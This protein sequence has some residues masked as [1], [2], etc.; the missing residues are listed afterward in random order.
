MKKIILILTLVSSCITVCAATES[1]YLSS[2][3]VVMTSF[4]VEEVAN[5]VHPVCTL[6]LASNKDKGSYN[7]VEGGI[8]PA[9]KPTGTETCAYSAI[10]ELNHK[11]IIAE[12][13]SSGKDTAI[14][15][16][17]DVTIITKKISINSATMDDEGEDVKYS[18]TIKTKGSESTE[19]MF[20]YCGI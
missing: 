11:I 19:N 13:V 8:C 6:S 18:I 10:I 9:G 1:N 3:Y 15:K 5:L 14:F 4:N 7:Y 17:K 2:D 20:G 16:N 12:Q